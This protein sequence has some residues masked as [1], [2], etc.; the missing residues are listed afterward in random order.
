M[1]DQSPGQFQF[2][3]GQLHGG[4]AFSAL[5]DQFVHGDGGGGEQGRDV[6]GGVCQFLGLG[7]EYGSALA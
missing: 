1:A 7:V 6:G 2:Q 4:G 5:A 3:Q